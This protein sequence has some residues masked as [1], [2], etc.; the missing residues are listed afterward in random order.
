MVNVG[1]GVSVH[2]LLSETVIEKEAWLPVSDLNP[3][4]SLI[5]FRMNIDLFESLALAELKKRYWHF[6]LIL[7]TFNFHVLISI[8]IT[9]CDTLMIRTWKKLS[10][11]NLDDSRLYAITF[12]I[13]AVIINKN[14]QIIKLSTMVDN[15]NKIRKSNS[16]MNNCNCSQVV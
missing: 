1:G 12:N 8:K 2:N 11:R 5:C 6:W 13:W 10:I 3:W 15:E 14:L 4:R 9:N 7:W 16:C